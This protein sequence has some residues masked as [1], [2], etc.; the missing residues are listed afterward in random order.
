[1][2][3]SYRTAEK[4]KC[5]FKDWFKINGKQTIK[6]HQK[7]AYIEVKNL[8]RK[9]KLPFIIYQDFE[10]TIVPEHN[11]TQNPNESYINK[12]QKRIVC[13]YG[14]KLSCVDDNLVSHLNHT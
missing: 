14:Y 11:E 12:Y 8:G 1:M 13:S 5:H 2:F 10:S 7:V 9:I 3:A 4:L 6:M